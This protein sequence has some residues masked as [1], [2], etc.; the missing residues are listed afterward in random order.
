MVIIV[1][2]AI[3]LLNNEI[4]KIHDNRHSRECISIYTDIEKITQEGGK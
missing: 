4:I 2:Y 3:F 1:A